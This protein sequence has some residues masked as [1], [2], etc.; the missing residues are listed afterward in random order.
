MK[1]FSFLSTAA[2]VAPAIAIPYDEYIL[3][4]RSRTLHP[5]SVHNTNGSVSNPENLTRSNGSTT[6]DGNAATSYDFGINI[7][8]VV[9]LNINS[10]S[11]SL[12]YIGVTFSESSY[13]ISNASSDATADAG[14]DETLW[15]HV[16]EPGRYTAPRKKERGG[17]RYMTLVHN[18]TGTVEVTSAEVHYT[19]MP[20]WEDDAIANYTGYFHCDDELLNRIW[21]AGAYTNQICTIDPTHGDSLI[22]IREINSSVSDATNVTWYYNT[23]ITNGTSTLV[24]GAKRDRLVWAGDMAIAVPGV[25]VSTNDVISIEN[26]LNSL[27]DIQAANGRLPYAGRPFPNS[28]SFTYHLY[29]LIGVADHYLYTGDID[30]LRSLWDQ[31]KLGLSWSLSYIDSSGLMNVTSPADWLRFGMGGHNVEAN[32]ILYYT[33]NHGVELAA[34]LNDTLSTSNWTTIAERIKTSANELLWNNEAGMYIDNETTTLMPQ[35]GNSWAVVA[36]LTVNSTQV[37]RISSALADRWTPYGA[38]ALEAADAISPFISG[39]EL[40]AHFLAENTTAGLELMRLQWG[41]MLDDPRMTNST[42]IEGYS[43]TGE[44]HYAPYLNDARI[45]HAHGWAT[46][47]TSSLTFYIA[48]IQLLSAG[49]KTWRIAPSLGDLKIADA[50]FS[51]DIGFFSAKT[52]VGDEGAWAMEFEAPQGTSGEV[53]LPK[54]GCVG[55]VV[56]EEQSGNYEDILVEVQVADAGPVTVDGLPGGKW[57]AKYE[58]SSS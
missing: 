25:V 18:S 10:V 20:H 49:G 9:S 40:Q 28:V 45:S 50:G 7:A 14:K 12:Q 55:R 24:D 11:D 22:H 8:G 13:W 17:F 57:S 23:T 26:S 56:L 35:D 37:Q 38:P 4:P 32:A 16:T 46:G 29:T 3:A 27:F 2:L 48:G 15:F 47:P 5:V 54:L 19:A 39:F 43:T 31:W 36:N 42:F 53:K 52:Q 1:L 30:Y 44:L 6:F 21:Y 51:T 58:C 41:F 33:I 34:A